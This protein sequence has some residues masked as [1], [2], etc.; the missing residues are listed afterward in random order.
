MTAPGLRGT[1]IISDKAVRR[2]AERAATEALPGPGASTTKG[3]ATVSGRRADVAVE[4]T[5]PYPTGLPE[6]VRSLQDHV[7]G[8]TRQL[9]GLDVNR[10]RV[11]VTALTP[12]RGADAPVSSAYPRTET[13]AAVRTPRRSW[14][15]RRLPMA[16]LTLGAAMACGALAVDLI[17]VHAAHRPPAAWRTGTLHWLSGHGPGDP[18]VLAGACAVALLGLLLCTLALAP[19]HRRLLAVTSPA[20]HLRAAVDRATVA[21]LVRD[22]VGETDGIGPVKVRVRRRRVT[23]RAGLAFGD[24]TTALDTVRNTARRVLADCALRRTPR[25][26]VT[27]RPETAWNPGTAEDSGGAGRP[28]STVDGQT[29]TEGAN[30]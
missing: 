15:R 19:G 30:Q 16:L 17:R 14:S 2:I 24:R 6:A 21:A 9:T 12:L 23:V 27:V 8:R 7:T 4:V 11:G 13:V 3:S 22:A 18:A 5:L 10:P 28:L 20:P 26:S 25:L 29:A 1:T